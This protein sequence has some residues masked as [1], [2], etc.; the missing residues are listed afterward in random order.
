MNRT[1]MNGI[2]H[3]HY[4]YSYYYYYP[5]YYYYYIYICIFFGGGIRGNGKTMGTT[6]SSSVYPD[7]EVFLSYQGAEKRLDNL[8]LS[9]RTETTCEGSGC[10]LK[11][12]TL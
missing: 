3:Y 12:Q 7:T 6:T 10:W 5:Y 9:W 4:Y 2:P 8:K 1:G 11:P